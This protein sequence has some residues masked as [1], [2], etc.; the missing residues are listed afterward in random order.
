H[1]LGG[2]GRAAAGIVVVVAGAVGGIDGVQ[3]VAVGDFHP[4]VTRDREQGG[5]VAL[6]VDGDH[7]HAIGQVPLFVLAGT[8][9][10]AQYEDGDAAGA[11]PG[12]DGD[13]GDGGGVG[14]RGAGGLVGARRGGGCRAEQRYGGGGRVAGDLPAGDEIAHTGKYQVG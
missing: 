8:A 13:G 12:L 14:R 7:H 11:S 5:R 3:A 6:R 10:D 9:V 2:Q 1:R 4:Q